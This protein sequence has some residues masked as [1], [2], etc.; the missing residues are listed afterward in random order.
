MNLSRD[1]S[2][3]QDQYPLTPSPPR[4]DVESIYKISNHI[5]SCKFYFSKSALSSIKILKRFNKSECEFN[6]SY[7]NIMLVSRI[8]PMYILIIVTRNIL[9]NEIVYDFLLSCNNDKK[10]Q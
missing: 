2:A 10:I 4:N 7:C 8:N 9:I 6:I 1:S 3:M 5:F